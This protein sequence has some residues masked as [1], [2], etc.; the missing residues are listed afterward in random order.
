LRQSTV[1]FLRQIPEFAEPLKQLILTGGDPL[2]R[3]D[4]GNLIDE[5]RKLRIGV[6]ITPEATPTLTREVMLRLKQH[7]VEGR[8][9]PN[10][11]PAENVTWIV[12]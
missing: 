4:L 3:T 9:W 12:T 6:S 1:A 2:A 8:P 11:L 7:G 5:A 10:S